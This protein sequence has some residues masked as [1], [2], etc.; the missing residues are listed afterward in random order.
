VLLGGR[1]AAGILV[2]RHTL[3]DGPTVLLVGCGL[4]LDWRGVERSGDA[5]GW[6]SLAEEIDG[7][8]DR[9]Q[10]L[11]DLLEQ[12][13]ARLAQLLVDPDGVL[14]VY[15]SLCPPSARGARRAPGWADPGRA[16][17]RHRCLGTVDPRG[18]HRPGG[19]RCRRCVPHRAA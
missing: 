16:G 13:G 12:L 4:D 6:T 11:V 8:V 10:V 17:Q 1:K 19:R 5:A 18:R 2:E 14:G 7:D 9:A 3:P 15:R